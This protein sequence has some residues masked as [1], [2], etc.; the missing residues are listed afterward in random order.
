MT[1]PDNCCVGTEDWLNLEKTRKHH[2]FKF[3]FQANRTNLHCSVSYV[4]LESTTFWFLVHLNTMET[5]RLKLLSRRLFLLVLAPPSASPELLQG[6]LRSWPN[7]DFF[8]W[9]LNSCC[10]GGRNWLGKFPATEAH[11]RYMFLN[12]KFTGSLICNSVVLF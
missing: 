9:S 8:S 10:C 3:S 4:D 1:D 6:K 2:Q 5:E 12:L 7:R 11:W